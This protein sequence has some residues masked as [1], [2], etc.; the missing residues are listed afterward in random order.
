MGSVLSLTFCT[1]A[2][3]TEVHGFACH[4]HCGVPRATKLLDSS[5]CTAIDLLT[6]HTASDLW[7]DS[8]LAKPEA[9]LRLLL[10]ASF[11]SDGETPQL[12]SV[13][14]LMLPVQ[15]Q[16]NIIWLRS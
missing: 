14:Y 7:A 11:V 15:L 8:F 2:S 16:A 12:M 6:V 1:A 4:L 5:W 3:S 10:A 9:I 13:L